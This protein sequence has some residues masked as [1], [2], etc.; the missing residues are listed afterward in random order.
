MDGERCVTRLDF[1]RRPENR[2]ALPR[3]GYRIGTYSDFRESIMRG[4]DATPEL[5]HWTHR[6]PDDPG[7][8]LLECAAVL[9]DILTFY[10]ELYA[11]EA[12]LRTATWRTSVAELVRLL[13]YR[14]APGLGGRGTFALLMRPGDPVAVPVGLSLRMEV[15]GGEVPVL[16]ETTEAA[17]AHAELGAFSLHRPLTLPQLAAGATEL[18]LSS[19]EAVELAPDDR[20]LVA[21]P[22]G[23]RRRGAQIVVVDELDSLHG[24]TIVR[25]KGS[26]RT[27]YPAGT[28]AF[29]LGRSFRHFG[30]N[31][32]P[33]HVRVVDGTAQSTSVSYCRSLE[34]TT[35][36][37]SGPLEPLALPLETPVDDLAAGTEVIC[38]YTGGCYAADEAPDWESEH[39][40]L[41]AVASTP[42]SRSWTANG[43]PTVSAQTMT[44]VA[45]TP[46][47]NLTTVGPGLQLGMV[48][49][50][51]RRTVR[52]TVAEVRADSLQLGSL[53]GATTVLALTQTLATSDTTTADIRSVEVHEVTSPQLQVAARPVDQSVGA[54][55]DLLFRGS[56]AAAAALAGRRVLIQRPGA[57]VEATVVE[58][59]AANDSGVTGLGGLHRITLAAEVDYA[60]FPQE[61]DEASA[62][63]VYGNVVDA[64]QG[65]TGREEV[66]GSGDGR[67]A[68]QTFKL[69]DSPLTYHYRADRSPPQVPALEVR[70]GGRLWTQVESLYEQGP[71][72]EVYIV[73]EDA[74][75]DSWVQFGD[76]E[77][78]GARLPS[79]PGNVTVT[80]R[81]GAGAHGPQKPDTRIQPGRVERLDRVVLPGE[82]SG[83]AE[84]E[85]AAV[86]R[87][88]APGRIQSLG[89]LVSLSDYESEALAM[90]GVASASAV[91]GLLDGVPAVSVTVLME[92]GREQEHA[93]IAT[94]LRTAARERGPDRF[95]IEVREGRFLDVRLHA[96]IAVAAG[97]EADAVLDSVATALGVERAGATRPASGL[98]SLAERRFGEP[99]QLTRVTGRI[100][101]VAGVAW[102]RVTAFRPAAVRIGA[103]AQPVTAQVDCPPH[104]MLRLVDDPA[105]GTFG[106]TAVAGP[107]AGPAAAAAV[108]T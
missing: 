50:R 94:A 42:A 51:P 88:S 74:A 52:R 99:E 33:D 76:G 24:E 29:R 48:E 70:V 75:G 105:A 56:E 73:R 104:R 107:A 59:V 55:H 38:T 2:P 4:L 26:L 17:T 35:Q 20:L 87:V 53:T 47:G 82:L 39:F 1:P 14:L 86:A 65:E 15:D 28:V 100:Q 61:P 96:E 103:A 9:G 22:S 8:A 37:D 93:A 5:A 40:Q 84:P 31:A 27:A 13:G 21:T 34:R 81:S 72:A 63:S 30:H 45:G 19:S 62:T 80:M 12:Y 43:Q 91:W 89:R 98:F 54:G 3:V 60:D 44:V 102:T 41:A 92:G 97:L 77:R 25:I 108:V 58:S 67:L 95:E 90:P 106:L 7:I 85:D 46:T 71:D 57:P 10:Q 36:L 11:N 69:P 78:F 49:Y 83:G 101:N 6:E 16:L 18:W 79:G 68:F 32:P 66:L 64:D 23:D